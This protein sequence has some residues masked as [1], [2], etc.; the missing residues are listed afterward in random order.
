MRTPPFRWLQYVLLLCALLGGPVG[1]TVQAQPASAQKI[2]LLYAY[3]YGGRGVELFSDGFF[4]AITAAGFPV[5]N[6]YAEYLDLQRNRDVPGYRQELLDVLRK[7]YAQRGIDLIVTVQQPA[8]EFLLTDGRDIEPGAP[9]VTIQHRPLLD[10]ERTGR[11]IVGEVNQFDI[12]GTLERALE[13]FPQTRRVLFASG[14]S[15]ADRKLA[16][17]AAR[18][19]EP[20]RGR[21]EFEYTLGKSRDENLQRVGELQP[22]SIVVLTQYNVDAKGRVA[23]A[24]RPRT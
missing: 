24:C 18:V 8:L 21:L 2:L 5:T 11:R 23:L 10:A 3:G 17:E 19:A 7:K 14:S 13:L 15:A 6:V 20:W 1:Q 4:K 22:H 16:E 9:V 12:K